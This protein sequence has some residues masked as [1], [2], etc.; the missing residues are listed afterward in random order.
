MGVFMGRMEAALT[1]AR[2]L[3]ARQGSPLLGYLIEMALVQC[4]DE[5]AAREQH[6]QLTG[7]P[8]QEMDDRTRAAP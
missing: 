4:M 2:L 8:P 1:E 5:E 3:A 6:E 7:A